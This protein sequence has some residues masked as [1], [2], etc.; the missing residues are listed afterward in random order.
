MVADGRYDIRVPSNGTLGYYVLTAAVR[1]GRVT[2]WS[3]VSPD[4]SLLTSA[5]PA[6]LA[7]HSDTYLAEIERCLTLARRTSSICRVSVGYS[8]LP[9]APLQFDGSYWHAGGAA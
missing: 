5:T 4:E 6:T 1:A 9:P 7:E 2:Y 8:P 3:T